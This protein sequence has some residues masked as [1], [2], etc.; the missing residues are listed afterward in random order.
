MDN[1]VRLHIEKELKDLIIN[2]IHIQELQENLGDIEHND[3][4]STRDFIVLSKRISAV[5][6][7]ID[8]SKQEGRDIYN[9]RYVKNLPWVAIAFKMHVSEITAKR[10]NK[11]LLESVG[12]NLGWI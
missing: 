6:R 7:G 3:F 5:E 11:R 10:Y 9:F 1:C 8:F 2:K 12:Y 4:V